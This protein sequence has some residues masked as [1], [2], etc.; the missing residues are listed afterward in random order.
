[1]IIRATI[2]SASGA[3]ILIHRIRVTAGRRRESGLFFPSPY[4]FS[5]QTDWPETVI[6]RDNRSSA[7]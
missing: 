6:I 1:M 3:M 4:N 2:T 7:S 5:Y